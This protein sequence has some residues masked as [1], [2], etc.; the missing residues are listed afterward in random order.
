MRGMRTVR[1]VVDVDAYLQAA[2]LS[3]L[4]MQ[5]DV[6]LRLRRAGL[7]IVKAGGPCLSVTVSAFKIKLGSAA[8]QRD[9]FGH[10]LPD[11][12]AYQY[13]VRLSQVVRLYDSPGVA[14]PC[15]TWQT[16]N[17]GKISAKEVEKLR[18][19]ITDSVDRF[20]NAYLAEN[21]R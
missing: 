20:L 7:Q 21:P 8:L 2:G 4:Q 18:G 9:V 5:T 12:F 19:D 13:T 14:A 16:G 17:Y 3:R 1:V 6:E 11:L 15:W 10:E